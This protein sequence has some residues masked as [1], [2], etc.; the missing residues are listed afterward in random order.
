MP[1]REVVLCCNIHIKHLLCAGCCVRKARTREDSALGTSQVTGVDAVLWITLKNGDMW[2][3]NTWIQLWGQKS[4][5]ENEVD[6]VLLPLLWSGP[7]VCCSDVGAPGDSRA[8]SKGHH[9][10]RTRCPSIS[11]VFHRGACDP[12]MT[13]TRTIG[14]GSADSFSPLQILYFNSAF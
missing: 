7:L 12:Q 5:I 10:P 4:D 3:R 8:G 11:S 6:V 1:K 9:E 13:V 14:R 2:R